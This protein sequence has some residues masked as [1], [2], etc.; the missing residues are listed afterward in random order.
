VALAVC[1]F[2]E[3][4][5]VDSVVPKYLLVSILYYSIVDVPADMWTPNSAL[6]LPDNVELIVVAVGVDIDCSSFLI[7]P[8]KITP[9]TTHSEFSLNTKSN[10]FQC[11]QI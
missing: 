2:F 7:S 1:G 6:L 9:I 4:L 5:V 8:F 11:C 10:V 3:E